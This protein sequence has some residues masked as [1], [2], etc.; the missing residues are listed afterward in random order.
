MAEV[1]KINNTITLPQLLVF[2]I[3]IDLS[4]LQVAE[5]KKKYNTI[6]L[7]QLLVFYITVTLY[8]RF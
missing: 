4:V 2:Y 5:V 7:P 1:K 8:Q 3:T 6:T